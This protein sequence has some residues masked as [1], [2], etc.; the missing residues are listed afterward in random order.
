MIGLGNAHY[1]AVTSNFWLQWGYVISCASFALIGGLLV[2][3]GR[4]IYDG[5]RGIAR[6]RATDKPYAPLQREPVEPERQ[7]AP[8]QTSTPPPVQQTSEEAPVEKEQT[9]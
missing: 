7:P 6:Y 8:T 5:I 3:Q 4:N 1:G 2:Y 9:A